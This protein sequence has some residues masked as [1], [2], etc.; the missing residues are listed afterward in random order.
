M[1][2]LFNDTEMMVMLV[3][4]KV[5]YFVKRQDT[6]IAREGAVILCSC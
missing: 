3:F 5:F 1:I 4:D 6:A 2:E